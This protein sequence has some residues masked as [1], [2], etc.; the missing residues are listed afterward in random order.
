LFVDTV[1]AIEYVRRDGSVASCSREHAPQELA[2]VLTG[3][4]QHGI[5]SNLTLEMIRVDKRTVLVNDRRIIRDVDAFVR[6]SHKQIL[7]GTG[8]LSRGFW[9]DRQMRSVRVR[10]GQLSTYSEVPQTPLIRMRRNVS[11]GWRR[12]YHDVSRHAP[13]AIAKAVQVGAAGASMF[14]PRYATIRDVE[15]A[16]DTTV[17]FSIGD[18]SQ[19]FATWVPEERYPELFNSLYELFSTYRQQTGCFTFL[20]VWVQGIRSRYLGGGE[21]KRF[22]AILL[23][24]GV[25]PDIFTGEMATTLIERMDDLCIR[26]GALRYMQTRTSTDGRRREMI[27]PNR[28]YGTD[29]REQAAAPT[30]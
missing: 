27:D 2:R 18:P 19:W 11:Q 22:A 12:A 17:E 25:R 13:T 4:G 21:E 10:V 29:A 26:E 24:C 20:G 16:A 30:A 3:R 8:V 6:R 28:L 5:I 15:Q 23:V 1:R 14:P 7:D 9:L